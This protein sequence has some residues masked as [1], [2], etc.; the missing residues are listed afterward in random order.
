[1]APEQASGFA[2]VDI[3]DFMVY[4]QE[5]CGLSEKMLKDEA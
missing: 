1:M 5:H 2:K 4:M 3:T